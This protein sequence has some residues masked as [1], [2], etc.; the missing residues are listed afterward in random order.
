MKTKLI[1][2][3]IFSFLLTQLSAQSSEF[4]FGYLFKEKMQDYGTFKLIKE[5]QQDTSKVIGSFVFSDGKKYNM[6]NEFKKKVYIPKKIKYWAKGIITKKSGDS[7][8]VNFW[9]V[10]DNVENKEVNNDNDYLNYSN[11]GDKKNYV[12]VI[13]SVK[14]NNRFFDFPF[15]FWQLMATNIPFRVLTKSG[16]LETDFLNVNAT[17]LKVS[18]HTRL[19]K[20][21]FVKQ[22]NRYFAYGPFLGLSTI[23]NTVTDKKE[24]GL[25]Y[26]VNVI[27]SVHGLNL[28]AAYGWQYGFKEET[29]TAQPYLGF[30][31]GFKLFETFNPE[32]KTS[33]E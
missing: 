2:A 1:F 11:T 17:F 22:K 18:G 7:V 32:I 25:N 27:G 5:T 21:K 16:A 3:L 30:G 14:Y 15:R 20:S 19:Y 31:I 29:K 26:G 28:I 8:Y 4:K 33:E 10:K 6:V 13:D 23:E 24:F 12:F 9:R